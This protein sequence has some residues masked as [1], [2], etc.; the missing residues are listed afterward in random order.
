MSLPW[1]LHMCPVHAHTQKPSRRHVRLLPKTIHSHSRCPRLRPQ[2]PSTPPKRSSRLTSGVCPWAGSPRIHTQLPA[3]TYVLRDAL[4]LTPP[5]PQAHC[6][7]QKRT[8]MPADASCQERPPQPLSAR[9]RRDMRHAAPA[10]PWASQRAE[11]VLGGPA[12]CR[13]PWPGCGGD[14]MECMAGLGAG[15][16]PGS[17]FRLDADR[18]SPLS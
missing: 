7:Q 16:S 12:P 4:T 18:P 15:G 14:P 5:L 8:W 11:G 1:W 13:T 6:G 3:R 10:E 2:G 9:G 17:G